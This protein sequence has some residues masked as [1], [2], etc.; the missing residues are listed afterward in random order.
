M[1]SETMVEDTADLCRRHLSRG[2]AKLGEMF[3]GQ[4]EVSSAG[5]WIHTADGGR[6]L[7]AGGYGVF[8]HGARHPAIEAAVIEQIR[9]HP[10]ASRLFLEPQAA[11]AAAALVA[12]CPPGLQRV[13]FAGSGAEATEAAIKMARTQGRARLISTVRGY[14]GKTMGA[15]SVTASDLFQEPFRPLLPGV[16]HIRYGD[17]A[18]LEAALSNGPPACVIVEPVQGE[19]GVVIPP[20][21]YLA[22]V[23][24][25]C[26]EHGAFLVLD[27]VLTGLGRLGHWWGADREAVTPDVLL[28]G[29]ALSGGVVPVSAA[30]ATGEAFRAFDRDPFLHTSTFAAAPI[31]M[32]AASAAIAAIRDDDLVGR[33]ASIGAGL[34]RR[35]RAAAEPY[36]HLVRET[37]GVGLLIA[38]EFAHPGLAGETLIELIGRGVI[39][40][41]SLNAAAVLRL[42]PPAVLTTAEAD[43]LVSAF[44]SALRALARRYPT[45]DHVGTH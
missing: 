17:A 39:V 21:G 34:L 8:L 1:T 25:L 7:N 20:A 5:A 27:E 32:A 15:L 14:H 38:L 12:V 24:R 3:G 2:R 42:T 19:A 11:R 44:A 45:A 33:A 22:D 28:V 16:C 26:R 4:V 9:T 29:K 30:V 10:L 23:A 18:A 35:L 40:N 37:R 31:A 41:H 6:F 36:P 13:H 43:L